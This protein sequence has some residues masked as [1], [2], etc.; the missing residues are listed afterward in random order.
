MTVFTVLSA[1]A[2]VG[3]EPDKILACPD[4]FSALR[5]ALAYSCRLID[6]VELA[7]ALRCSPGYFA[8]IANFRPDTKLRLEQE[9]RVR[10]MPDHW[11]R[12]ISEFT[13]NTILTDWRMMSATGQIEKQRFIHQ[14]EIVYLPTPAMNDD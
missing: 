8:S 6:G 7:E 1:V 5:L 10:H 9:V 14:G 2:R 11:D 3:P 12:I 13:G 4:S